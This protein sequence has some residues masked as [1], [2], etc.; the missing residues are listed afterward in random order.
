MWQQNNQYWAENDIIKIC[1]NREE[2]PPVDDFRREYHALPQT[3]FLVTEKVNNVTH[4]KPKDKFGDPEWRKGFKPNIKWSDKEATHLCNGNNQ[5][6]RTFE[7]IINNQVLRN[8]SDAEK[9]IEMEKVII[10]QA[11]RSLQAEL[12]ARIQQDK[13]KE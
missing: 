12:H 7:K 1:D 13:L 9:E 3:K 10:K 4:W 11:P 5:H 8:K 6:F 2:C